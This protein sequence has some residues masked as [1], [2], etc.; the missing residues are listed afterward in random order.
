MAIVASGDEALAVLEREKGTY[1]L[2]ILDIMLPGMDGFS[3]LRTIREEEDIPVLLVSARK[4]SC[5]KSKASISEPMTISETVQ[6]GG[7]RSPGE[8]ASQPL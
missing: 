8:S 4:R 3:V 5:T 2:V 1:D 7:T 6:F